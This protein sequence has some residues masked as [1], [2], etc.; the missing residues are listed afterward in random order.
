[1]LSLIRER[2]MFATTLSRI[3]TIA[4]L[5]ITLG[6]VHLAKSV[7]ADGKPLPAGTYQIRVT[8]EGPAPAAGQSADSEKWV[9]FLQGGK[10]VG[11]EVASIIPQSEIAEHVK[12]PMPKANGSRVDNLKGGDYVRVWIHKA[13]KHYLI[14]L[15]AGK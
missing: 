14:N 12:G 5:A 4:T 2:H 15:G 8:D 3:A 7:V 9:E 11:R 13:D 10:V 6:T 1:M